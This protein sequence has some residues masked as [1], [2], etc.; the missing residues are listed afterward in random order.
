MLP[1]GHVEEVRF[2]DRNAFCSPLET[3]SMAPALLTLIVSRLHFG[4]HC[5]GPAMALGLFNLDD[6]A[7][8]IYT[9]VIEHPGAMAFDHTQYFAFSQGLHDHQ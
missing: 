2:A 6:A 5:V 4:K 7:S 3:H 1:F 9:G 8:L